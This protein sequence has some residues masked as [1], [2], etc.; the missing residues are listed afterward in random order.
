MASAEHAK[1]LIVMGVSGTGKSSVAEAL[2]QHFNYRYL[3]ADDFHSD[4]AK[5][6]M[7]SG[8]PLTDA[9]RVPWVHNIST[10]LRQCA[11]SGTSCTLAFSGLRSDHRQ[12]LR[13]LPFQRLFFYLTGDKTTIAE[14]MSS[15]ENHFMP[16]SLL[17]SQLASMQSPVDEPEVIEVSITPPLDQVIAHCITHAERELTLGKSDDH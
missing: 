4:E 10:Y 5:A 9:I 12:L 17:D 2:A 16:S 3:D 15:R 13:Q 14:R 11:N 6:M 8:T 1:L 7:A